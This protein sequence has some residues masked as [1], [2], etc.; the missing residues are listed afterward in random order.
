MTSSLTTWMRPIGTLLILLALPAP[1]TAVKIG[2]ITHLQG[3]RT[4]KL[5]GM[6]LVMGLK[7]TGDGGKFS[8]ALRSLARLYKNYGIEAA[9]LDDLKSAKNVA[10]VEIEAIL[11]E[12][13]VRE[14]DRV[15]VRVISAGAAK[16]LAGGHL[17][18]TPLVSGNPNDTRVMAMASGIVQIPDPEV[19][20][21]GRIAQGATLERD[22]IH[23]YV[24]L[25][26]ELS[27]YMTRSASRPLDWIRPD[28]RYVTFVIDKAHAEWSIAHTI[29]QCINEEALVSDVDAQD[30]RSQIAVAFDP[31]TVIVRLPETE[32]NNPAPFLFRIEK[33]HLIM[34]LTEARVIIDRAS[35]TVVVKGDVEIA[36]VAITHKGMTIVTT[37]AGG[38]EPDPTATR[39]STGA[40]TALDPQRKG[41]AKLMDL[42]EAL[43][44]L[45]VPA[46]DRIAII[47]NLHKGGQLHAKLI[48]EN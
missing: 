23:N 44:Q 28:D 37:T 9:E 30:A 42:I 6:G 21:V 25:G 39:T 24:A 34:P 31:R 47:E 12:E 38:P 43:N 15:D 26:R 27:A 7:G 29:A 20:T 3:S 10:I 45:K 11:P 48:V 33:M 5:T 19:P 8:P 4:N 14:G 36:P 1:A 41:G 17:F 16:S 40:F 22:F 18:M 35:G 13:G 32:W 2:D 46:A